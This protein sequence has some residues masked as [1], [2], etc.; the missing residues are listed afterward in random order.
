LQEKL[1]AKKTARLRHFRIRHSLPRCYECRKGLLFAID[2][3]KRLSLWE[4]KSLR[5][6]VSL[7]FKRVSRFRSALAF[8]KLCRS[9]VLEAVMTAA[10]TLSKSLKPAPNRGVIRL[11]LP[12]L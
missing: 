8:I 7:V 11:I 1:E 3:S 9:F 5:R 4:S 12:V 6:T 10:M 2:S